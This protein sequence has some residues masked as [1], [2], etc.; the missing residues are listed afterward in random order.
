MT[1]RSHDRRHVAYSKFGSKFLKDK[2]GSI[3]QARTL[4]RNL[5]QLHGIYRHPDTA[6]YLS[7][8][9]RVEVKVCGHDWDQASARSH[10]RPAPS[11]LIPLSV[12]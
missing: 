11:P 6:G 1:A 2:A 3:K 5:T 10:H 7:K 12:P 4:T 8:G 9:L